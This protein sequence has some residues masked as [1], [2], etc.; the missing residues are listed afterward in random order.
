MISRSTGFSHDLPTVIAI[1]IFPEPVAFLENSEGDISN[2]FE[3]VR[4][5]NF[6]DTLISKAK[7]QFPLCR[8]DYNVQVHDDNRL[9]AEVVIRSPNGSCFE[10]KDWLINTLY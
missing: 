9:Y 10:A 2:S 7:E 8:F 4:V 1:C 5:S 6:A 3:A